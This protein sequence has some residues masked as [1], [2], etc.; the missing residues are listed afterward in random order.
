MDQLSTI[1]NNIDVPLVNY[2]IFFL[3]GNLNVE[4]HSSFLK[5]FC[6]GYNLKNLIKVATSVRNPVFPTSTDVM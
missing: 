3:M 1:E 4:G 2:E 5:E 6:D